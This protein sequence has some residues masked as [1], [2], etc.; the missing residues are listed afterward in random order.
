MELLMLTKPDEKL[1]LRAVQKLFLKKNTKSNKL[2]VT[3]FHS[4]INNAGY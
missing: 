4:Y 3:K 1:A 2:F